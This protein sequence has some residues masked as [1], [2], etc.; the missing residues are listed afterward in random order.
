M[1]VNKSATEFDWNKGNIGKNRKHKVDDKEAEEAFFDKKKVVYKDEF[2]SQNERRF[3]LLGRTKKKR[4][5]Y[6]SFTR[7]GEQEEKIWIISARDTNK[8]EVKFYIK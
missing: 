6:I 2:H 1:V 8:K 7:R 3:I 5:L 4:L